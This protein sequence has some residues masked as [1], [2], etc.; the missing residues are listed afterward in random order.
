VEIAR[1][2][3]SIPIPTILRSAS[4]EFRAAYCKGGTGSL[5]LTRISKNDLRAT[6][7]AGPQSGATQ[8][9]YTDYS[10]LNLSVFL[11]SQLNQLLREE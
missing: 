8:H 10:K 2:D 9:S 3:T 4:A 7:N 11:R 6:S 1:N 5:D